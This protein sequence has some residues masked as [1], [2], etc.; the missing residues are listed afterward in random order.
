MNGEFYAL[1]LGLDANLSAN[2]AYA[3]ELRRVSSQG[4]LW[5]P[6]PTG[7]RPLADTGQIL[8]QAYWGLGYILFGSQWTQLFE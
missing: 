7:Y 8:Y 5:L 3:L 4:P 6:N 1:G 2:F